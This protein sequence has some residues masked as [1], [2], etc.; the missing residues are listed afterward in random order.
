MNKCSLILVLACSGLFSLTINAQTQAVTSTGET[1]TLYENG[2][3]EYVGKKKD[4]EALI[5]SSSFTKNPGASF[6]VKSKRTNYGLYIDPT[7]WRIDKKGEN[8]SD[9]EYSFNFKNGS[10]YA[11]MITEKAELSFELL[12]EAALV[13][14]RAAAPDIAI[15]EEEYRIV[16]NNKVLLLQLKGTMKGLSFSYYGYYVTGQSGTIQLISFTTSKLFNEHKKEMET[17]LNGLIIQP[18][19]SVTPVSKM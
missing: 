4:R 5:N 14:G 15:V 11:V 1:V 6:L 18:D 7:K 16:N 10:S 17:F 8:E 9:A 12:K 2:T 13:N 3:W 19:I